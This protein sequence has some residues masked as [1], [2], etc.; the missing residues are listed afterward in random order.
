M[1]MTRN[2]FAPASRM[3][4]R[5]ILGAAVA[6]SLAFAVVPSQASFEAFA[7]HTAESTETV[8]HT[9][10][11]TLLK[12]YTRP[13]AD[14]INYIDYAGFKAKGHATL[15][16]YVKSLEAVDPTK[17]DRNEQFAYWANLYNAKT[18]DV[19][20]DAYPVESIRKITINEGVV[21][22]FKKAAGLA[23]PWKAEIMNVNG[24]PLSLDN[25]EHDIMRPVFKDPR[26]HYAV[27]CASMGCPNLNMTAFTGVNLEAELERGAKA[28]VNH[29]R[30]INVKPD[31]TIVA[32]SIYS[33]FQV[34]FGGTPEGVLDHVR[35]YA[36]DELK[37]KLDGKT[38]IADF[39]YDWN[40][41]DIP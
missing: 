35:K 20:L 19:V 34:D 39:E 2:P 22:F 17:L 5:A 38:T 36:D 16:A 31:G 21:G 18:I 12:T 4:R 7:K 10:W 11:D 41:N 1:I 9:A 30:G 26:V 15:K 3:T 27:N 25:V 14:G 13:G 33:W 24:R 8:D 23:G 32:S 40:L 6:A 28:F 29:P 37:A